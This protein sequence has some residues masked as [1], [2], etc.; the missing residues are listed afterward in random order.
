MVIEIFF[1]RVQTTWHYA[2]LYA[3]PNISLF[4][5]SSKSIGTWNQRS[6][7]RVPSSFD[8][9]SNP[10]VLYPLYKYGK[11]SKTREKPPMILYPPVAWSHGN[12]ESLLETCLHKTSW[13]ILIIL[14]FSRAFLSLG[15]FFRLGD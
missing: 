15:E 3:Q 13:Q 12:W 9:Q 14:F 2:L 5:S 10:L 8:W 6:E 7:A 11:A 1:F 4:R